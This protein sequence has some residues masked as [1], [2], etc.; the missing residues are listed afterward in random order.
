MM[1]DAVQSSRQM[2]EGIV[3]RFRYEV[4]AKGEIDL[5]P[6][7]G[8]VAVQGL[9]L[10]EAE[11]AITSRLSESV[12]DFKVSLRMW[13]PDHISPGGV[14]QIED[15]ARELGQFMQTPQPSDS[16]G[17]LRAIVESK[18]RE[19]EN[20][21]RD[22]ANREVSEA[23]RAIKQGELEISKARY[24]QALRAVEYRLLLIDLATLAL[25]QARETNEATPGAV[26]EA[27][28]RRLGILVE[29]AKAKYAEAAQ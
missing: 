11:A 21:N 12:D 16:L 26:P 20:L 5:G 19:L 18:D 9:T 22:S 3:H 2:D 14:I 15:I 7:F 24:R 17:V 13:P 27:E 1:L 23:E 4:D 29:L 10:K 25:K 28:I 6:H 8:R